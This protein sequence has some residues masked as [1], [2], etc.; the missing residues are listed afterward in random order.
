MISSLFERREH[1]NRISCAASYQ[2]AGL[3]AAP[4]TVDALAAPLLEVRQ[5]RKC[6]GE[7]AAVLAADLEVRRGEI[8]AIVGANGSGKTTLANII[9]GVYT[10][11][12]GELRLTG[13]PV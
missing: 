2:G 8:H 10:P 12:A 1:S 7:S 11:D 13:L 6:F 5:V 3:D 9:A 4:P